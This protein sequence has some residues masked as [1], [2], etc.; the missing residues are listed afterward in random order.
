MPV[1]GDATSSLAFVS[2]EVANWMNA[3][4]RSAFFVFAVITQVKPATSD[5]RGVVLE[6]PTGRVTT[7]HLPATVE[8][9][10]GSSE[11]TPRSV[12][13]SMKPTLPANQALLPAPKSVSAGVGSAYLF[14]STRAWAAST[15]AS[16]SSAGLPL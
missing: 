7:P 11:R 16:E 12:Q 10:D 14:T 4:A 13:F 6:P 9:L 5:A 8:S 3:F 2:D 15:A 1:G